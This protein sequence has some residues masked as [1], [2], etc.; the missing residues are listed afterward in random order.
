MSTYLI[1]DI[2]GAL[3]SFIL[4]LSEIG[5]NPESGRDELYLMGDYADWGTHSIETIGYIMDLDQYPCVH[6]L[7]GNHD[8]MFLQAIR[9][10]KEMMFPNLTWYETNK[11]Y[12][13]WDD[14]EKLSEKN[15]E[16]V[17]KWLLTLDFSADIELNGRYYMAAHAYPY[18]GNRGKLGR[19]YTKNNAVWHRVNFDENPFKNYHGKKKYTALIIGHT[20]TSYFHACKTGSYIN[21]PNAIFFGKYIIAIDCGAK[22]LEYPEIG[23]E[24]QNARLAALRLDD[25]KCYYVR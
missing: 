17:Y 25:N 6:C 1:S 4:L 22:A 7:M 13:T 15:R 3:E 2:H 9:E 5:F 16:A 20:P 12:K 8:L 24:S 11:G 14:Y 18:F 19:F 21:E 23:E 10:Y